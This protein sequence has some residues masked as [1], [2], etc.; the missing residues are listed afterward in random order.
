M[1]INSA[2]SSSTS[3]FSVSIPENTNMNS[4]KK[5]GSW[6]KD[7][8]TAPI[9]AT[10]FHHP[11]NFKKRTVGENW[12]KVYDAVNEVDSNT[13]GKLEGM[14]AADRLKQ[15]NDATYGTGGNASETKL[16]NTVFNL[17]MMME[18]D[19]KAKADAAAATDT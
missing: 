3:T 11:F 9:E 1:A 16:E 6:S 14:I 4:K 17:R 7:R 5:N 13:C 19:K 12:Q 10:I 8:E 18:Q 15:I 2:P